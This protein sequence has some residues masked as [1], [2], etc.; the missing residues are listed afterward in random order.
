MASARVQPHHATAGSVNTAVVFTSK[1]ATL[2]KA[3]AQHLESRLIGL[4]QEAKRCQLDNANTP[5]LPS[6]SESD[7]ATIEAFLG[8]MLQWHNE[9][10]YL[11]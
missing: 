6:L 8:E 1:D 11:G 2:N 10:R 3:H 7:T 9:A 5:Q 4:A